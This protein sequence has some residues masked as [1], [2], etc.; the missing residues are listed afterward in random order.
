MRKIAAN[1][2]RRR[3]KYGALARGAVARARIEEPAGARSPRVEEKLSVSRPHVW[4][5][6][7]TTSGPRGEEFLRR[8][9]EVAFLLDLLFGRGTE[10]YEKHYESGLIDASFGA[11]LGTER[12]DHAYVVVDGETDDPDALVRAVVERISEGRE[13][14]LPSEDFER[15]K[16]KAFG[17]FLRSFN[18]LEYV[19]T[20][21]AEAYLQGWDFLRYL[22]VLEPI[23]LA[24]VERNLA[25]L[26]PEAGRAVSIVR[27]K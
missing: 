16:S 24:E 15:I 27:P 9:F 14:G 25:T 17:R 19:G 10:F 8:E 21:Y 22:D 2:A 11:S 7:K 23:T 26:F 12:E 18:S 13:R 20:G 4:V 1:A 5:G 3:E 6:W